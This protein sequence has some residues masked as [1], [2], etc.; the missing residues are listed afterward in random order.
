MVYLQQD[1]KLF[2]HHPSET[3]RCDLPSQSLKPESRLRI[4]SA[5][6]AASPSPLHQSAASKV[7]RHRSLLVHGPRQPSAAVQQQPSQEQ[8]QQQQ[9]RR[10]QQRQQQQIK[11]FYNGG[12]SSS[13]MAAAWCISSATLVSACPC[14]RYLRSP[15]SAPTSHAAMIDLCPLPFHSW[16]RIFLGPRHMVYVYQTPRQH[17]KSV[18]NIKEYLYTLF[19]VFKKL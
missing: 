1:P 13:S 11:H 9:R 10:Q 19:N 16:R 15:G 4:R 8:Q 6:P 7:F 17:A 5:S 14:N 18:Y 2:L 12:I 3:D